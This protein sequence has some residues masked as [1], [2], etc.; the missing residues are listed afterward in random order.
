MSDCIEKPIVNPSIVLREEFDDWAI[1]Y[2]P[3]TG[4]AYGINPVGAYIWK[5]LDGRHTIKDVTSD[6][7]A[8][9]K[10]VPENV[11]ECLD[12]FIKELASHGMVGAETTVNKGSI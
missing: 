3:D 12:S 1:L 5:R 10:G 2:D 9:Y 7:I 11:A 6:L 8:E 4:D